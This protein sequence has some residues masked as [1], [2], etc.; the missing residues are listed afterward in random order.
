MRSDYQHV[1]IEAVSKVRKTAQQ[2]IS[3]KERGMLINVIMQEIYVCLTVQLLLTLI[4]TEIKTKSLQLTRIPFILSK[5]FSQSSAVASESKIILRLQESNNSTFCVNDHFY[6]VYC[7]T[8]LGIWGFRS[9]IQEVH[10][11]K[12][13]SKSLFFPTLQRFSI[14]SL[15]LTFYLCKKKKIL[16]IFGNC[17]PFCLDFRVLTPCFHYVYRAQ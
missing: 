6:A 5:K 2:C 7:C 14:N 10:D 4:Q 12:F 1:V 13:L 17:F 9:H 3:D 11:E 15:K 8:F 16:L